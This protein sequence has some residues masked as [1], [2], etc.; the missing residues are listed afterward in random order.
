MSVS[1]K[2]AALGIGQLFTATVVS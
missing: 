2:Q 1:Q